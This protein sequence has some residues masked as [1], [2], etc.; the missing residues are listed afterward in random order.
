MSSTPFSSDLVDDECEIGIK[1]SSNLF[2]SYVQ[3]FRLG[4]RRHD[5]ICGMQY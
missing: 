1:F 2:F 5:R 4:T 3:S